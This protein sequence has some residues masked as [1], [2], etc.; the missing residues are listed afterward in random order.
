LN[1]ELWGGVRATV[2]HS[3]KGAR[4]LARVMRGDGT[5]VGGLGKSRSGII[6]RGPPIF[7]QEKPR[8][9]PAKVARGPISV[10]WRSRGVIIKSE[11]TYCQSTQR[12]VWCFPAFRI[13]KEI[14]RRGKEQRGSEGF[15]EGENHSSRRGL[16]LEVDARNYRGGRA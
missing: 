1:E 12:W 2:G 16:M 8:H 11:K 4:L 5:F 9:L 13:V 3:L 7:Q 6:L 14:E 15:P 10:W